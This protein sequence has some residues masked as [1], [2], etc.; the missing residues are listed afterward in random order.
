MWL[1]L[2][3]YSVKVNGILILI[4]II[5]FIEYKESMTNNQTTNKD[6][7]VRAE[8]GHLRPAHLKHACRDSLTEKFDNI[9]IKTLSDK[10]FHMLSTR[11]KMKCFFTRFC[12]NV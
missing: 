3:F 4:I 7:Q 10:L 1:Q 11:L 6:V 5:I 8:L 12:V 2:Y 9:K